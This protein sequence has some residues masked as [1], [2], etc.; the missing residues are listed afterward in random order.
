MDKQTDLGLEESP[1]VVIDN[2]TGFIK[3]GLAGEDAPKHIF[4]T[5]V[6]RPQ[7]KKLHGDE[8]KDLFVGDEATMKKGVLKLTYP[9]DNGIVQDKSDM[10]AVW[11]YAYRGVLNN[12]SPEDQPVLLTEA[13]LNPKKNREEML[14]IFMENFGVP[15][16]YVF[17]QAV[18]ALYASG[19]TTG[20][21]VD[22]GDGVTHVVVVYDG[23]CIDPAT[24]RMDVAGRTITS[25]LQ[26]NLN[27]D[28]YSFKTSAE[29][30]IVR[31]IKEKVSRVALNYDEEMKQYIEDENKK[32]EYELPD[33]TKINIG[34]LAIRSGE[35]LFKP[36][37]IGLDI[38]NLPQTIQ[39]SIKKA[40]IDL[41]RE[42]YESIVLSGGTT[43]LEGFPERL[44]KEMSQLV[45]ESVNVKI[46]HPIE[47]KYSIWIGGSVLASLATF[48]NNWITKAEYDEIGSHIVHT[49][50]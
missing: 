49:K 24:A 40:S 5:I 13:P 25:F 14:E 23:Y 11:R 34:D 20:V 8:E 43:M 22:S 46:T 35:I 48:Q 45:P 12:Q 4:P 41:R 32:V 27:E 37:I 17:T 38:P 30:V 7:H 2:G 1:A 47:R 28:G 50:C 3:A 44:N 6:G 15:G 19:R 10:E 26:D 42:L 18:L 21:I 36:D 33:G 9:I 29:G 16:F 39:K 31:E